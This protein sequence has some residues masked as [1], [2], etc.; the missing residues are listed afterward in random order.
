MFFLLSV[1]TVCVWY[2]RN[3]PC[4]AILVIG[5]CIRLYSICDCFPFC[6]CSADCDL[7]VVLR[8]DFF[9]KFQCVT[10]IISLGV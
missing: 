10:F 6:D 8:L 2:T 3:G 7:C 5:Y 4:R 9:V 1:Y